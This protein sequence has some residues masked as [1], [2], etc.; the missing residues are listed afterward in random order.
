MT[1][2]RGG[3]VKVTTVVKKLFANNKKNLSANY[4][5]LATTVK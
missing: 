5:N 1:D 4:T 2:K 3:N